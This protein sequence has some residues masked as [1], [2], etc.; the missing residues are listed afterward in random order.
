MQ[1]ELKQEYITRREFDQRLAAMQYT[2]ET[3]IKNEQVLRETI[4]SK[5]NDALQ[6]Q[7]HENQ[8]RLGELNHAHENAMEN[9]ARSLPRE[10]FDAWLID[11]NRWRDDV[12]KDRQSIPQFQP[13]FNRFDDRIKLME[14]FSNKIIGGFILIGLMGVA[15]VIALAL[16]LMRL[17][18]LIHS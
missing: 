1:E 16:G 5:L 8:R 15:G 13:V 10:L 2:V 17:A 7:A 9:W 12:N 4:N 14:T 11:F 18:G 6:L 3:A